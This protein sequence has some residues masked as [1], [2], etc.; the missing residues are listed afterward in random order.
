MVT[1]T[2][3]SHPFFGG[4]RGLYKKETCFPFSFLSLNSSL[5]FIFFQKFPPRGRPGGGGSNSQNIY[6]WVSVKG[7]RSNFK[8][9]RSKVKGQRSKV[10]GVNY[11]R[12]VN[13]SVNSL[14]RSM[15]KYSY[16]FIYK[17]P[18]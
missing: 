10:K 15:V 6:P 5:F 11:P 7:Q 18:L 14:E 4:H 2:D 8:G 13:V 1:Q 16:S 3:L 12:M 9:Q 17:N